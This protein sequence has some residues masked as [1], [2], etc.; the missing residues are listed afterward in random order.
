MKCGKKK[1][2]KKHP[3]YKISNKFK[4]TRVLIHLSFIINVKENSQ[5][6]ISPRNNYRGTS[7]IVRRVF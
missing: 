1:K 4:N 6:L 3:I 5:N 2:T 7:D